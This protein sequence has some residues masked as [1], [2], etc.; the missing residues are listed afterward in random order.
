M[1]RRQLPGDLQLS[2][3]QEPP[4]QVIAG[5]PIMVHPKPT[6]LLE[7]EQN[8]SLWPFGSPYSWDKSPQRC[9][10]ANN[11]CVPCHR[12]VLCLYETNNQ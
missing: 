5:E 4:N 12:W 11:W 3:F 1:K 2:V 8:A 10:Q 7:N 6:R 9:L